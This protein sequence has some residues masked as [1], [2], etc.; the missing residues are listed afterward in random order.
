MDLCRSLRLKSPSH[1]DCTPLFLTQEPL[2]VWSLGF[3]GL[4]CKRSVH[5]CGTGG[6]GECACRLWYVSYGHIGL[7][8][9]AIATVR[10]KA[11][12]SEREAE[13]EDFPGVRY[14]SCD[15]WEPDSKWFPSRRTSWL[16]G[17]VTVRFGA[18]CR[19]RL[20]VQRCILLQRLYS[21]DPL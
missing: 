14:F 6:T 16:W 20:V 7:S 10:W 1:T 18:R 8:A 19:T 5:V 15:F 21:I 2:L 12:M 17:V 3:L 11:K 9:T 13:F 4:R